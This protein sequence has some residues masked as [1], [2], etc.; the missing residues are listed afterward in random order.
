MA[1]MRLG[2]NAYALPQLTCFR[3][4]RSGKVKNFK[5][6]LVQVL[7]DI[8]TL[9]AEGIQIFKREIHCGPLLTLYSCGLNKWS[10]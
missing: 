7:A 4:I 2:Q 8:R 10:T 1:E 9:N 5:T 6:G 3:W